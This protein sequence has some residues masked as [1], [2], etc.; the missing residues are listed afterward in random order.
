M[1]YIL[2]T[3]FNISDSYRFLQKKN[4]KIVIY[5]MVTVDT[6]IREVAAAQLVRY[7]LIRTLYSMYSPY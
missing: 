5:I 3:Y 6:F 7:M 1:L 4:K 2:L